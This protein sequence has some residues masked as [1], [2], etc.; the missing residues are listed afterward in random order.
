MAM[1]TTESRK[2]GIADGLI[3]I[4]GMAAGLGCFRALAPD[5]TP[6]KMWDAFVR[7]KEGWS[8]WYAFALSVELGVSLGIPFLAAWTP[9][10]LVVQLIKP[11]ASWRRLCRQP[12]F[13]ASLI[14]TNVIVLTVAAS[15]IS[16]WLSIWVATSSSP[17]RFM[18]A[19]LL[20][21]ILTG[22][23]VLWSWVTMRLCGVYRPRP[24]WTDRLGRLTGAAW[25][26]IGAMSAFFISLAIN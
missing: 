2:F 11:R 5:I 23:G 26:V 21:G 4:A 14:A 15:A 10:C 18:K 13:I 22:S 3:L 17:D 16:V 1:K 20:G 6:E 12:G 9:T 25:V 24:T 19:Y 7:P 8:F